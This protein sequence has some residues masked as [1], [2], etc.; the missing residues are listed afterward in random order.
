MNTNIETI[1]KLV[2]PVLE[3]AQVFLVDMQLRGSPN[4]QVLSIFVDTE[5]GVTLQQ[6]ATVTRE[7]EGLLDLEDPIRGKYRLDISSPGIDRP[8]TEIWQFKKNIGRNLKV[9]SKIGDT[10]L[11]ETGQ[12]IRVDENKLCLLRDEKEINIPIS[13]IIKAVIQLKW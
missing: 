6:I 11:E 13:Q 12:L 9:H 1:K 5:D 4:S 8:L 10:I 2:L 3:N 7:I